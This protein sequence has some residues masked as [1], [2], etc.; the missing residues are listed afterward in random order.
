MRAA[1]T[2]AA[3]CACAVL[4]LLKSR[5]ESLEADAREDRLE[6]RGDLKDA[7]TVSASS[8]HDVYSNRT[9][10]PGQTPACL[11]AAHLTLGRPV[12]TRLDAGAHHEEV[13]DLAVERGERLGVVAHLELG[14]G[15]LVDKHGLA[16]LALRARPLEF[17]G[18][19]HAC[20]V[21]AHLHLDGLGRRR[22]LLQQFLSRQPNQL[23]YAEYIGAI[24]KNTTLLKGARMVLCL[25]C[26]ALSAIVL[27]CSAGA[28]L[29]WRT[30][31]QSTPDSYGTAS[32]RAR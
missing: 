23:L 16:L 31:R 30:T 8:E 26:W 17:L 25:D 14:V 4:R 18:L 15:D 19:L 6:R 29:L 28:N 2:C 7:A 10:I 5:G 3:I 24:V 20:H 13:E 1:P 32:G 22:I 21:E 12:G 9:K 27:A 11:R